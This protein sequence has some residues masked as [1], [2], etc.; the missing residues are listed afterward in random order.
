MTKIV[1]LGAPSL[2]GKD[3]NQ[4]VAEAF[5]DAKY[6]LTVTVKNHMPRDVVFPEVP[7]LFLKHVA[8]ATE[9]VKTVK[10][11]SHD[12]FQRVASSIEQIAEL[13]RY[14]LAVTISDG[15]IPTEAEDDDAGGE[16]S[17]TGTGGEGGETV[18]KKPSEGLSYDQL[19]D[20]LKAKGIDFQANAK[21]AD[22]AALLDAAPAAA[23]GDEKPA[24]DAGG[25]GSG[26]AG[27]AN[28]SADGQA[29]G[30]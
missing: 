27:D 4:L 7:G 1:K 19:K 17:G 14:K 30:E 25:E 8:H 20:A 10:V 3:A 18:V 2:T 16:G 15:A 23:E 9:S 22:L 6:P 12:L 5:A 28:G 11:A 21:K 13:N 29:G 26:T 24:G